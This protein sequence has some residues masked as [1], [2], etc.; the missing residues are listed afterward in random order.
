MLCEL[1]AI[2]LAK[3]C[4]AGVTT[5]TYR[6]SRCTILCQSTHKKIS[7]ALAGEQSWPETIAIFRRQ[8]LRIVPR[9]VDAPGRKALSRPR[10]TTYKAPEWA[11]S[12]T[13]LPSP[14][15]KKENPGDV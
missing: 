14:I 12:L 1:T 13:G 10:A 2:P 3:R 6:Y 7:V 5:S 11:G 4:G 9:T 15:S 8:T